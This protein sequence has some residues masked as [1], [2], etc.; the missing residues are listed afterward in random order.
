MGRI[1]KGILGG[2]SGKVGTVV[3]ANW[4]SI[5]YMRSLPQ[6]VRNPRTEAQRKQ[7]GKFALV[8]ALLKPLIAVLRIGW[9][10]VAKNQSPTNSAMAYTLANAVIGTFPDFKI[11][12]TKV[13][14]SRG[15][16]LPAFN[17][18]VDFSAGKLN[19]TWDNNSG[20]STAKA[21]DK[22]LIVVLNS[23]KDETVSLMEGVNRAKGSH[24]V[25][26]PNG[27]E[28][29]K[30]NVYLGFVSDDGKEVANS[31]HLGEVTI[32]NA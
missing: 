9:K 10:N 21:T 11:D 1:K 23:E 2:F 24:A 15:G 17:G 30:V 31:V 12:Y 22:A 25:T 27:W 20:I 26:V 13:L 3:G 5:S 14:I 32:P 16:L 7:R 8:M 4:K 28:F 18:A 6:K 29:N 19:L